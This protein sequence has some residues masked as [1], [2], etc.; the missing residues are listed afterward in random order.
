MSEVLEDMETMW[1]M[2]LIWIRCLFMNLFR[3]MENSEVLLLAQYLSEHQTA[4][5][6]SYP[7][8][9]SS[10]LPVSHKWNNLHSKITNAIIQM[11][12]CSQI[13]A[14]CSTFSMVLVYRSK[15]TRI[16]NFYE[17]LQFV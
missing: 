16:Q 14:V 11:L 12:T 8:E 1:L 17:I 5:L 9:R 13:S 7:I 10:F 6:F 15:Q 4:H 3:Q 2:I